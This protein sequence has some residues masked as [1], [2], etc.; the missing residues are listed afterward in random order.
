ME[1]ERYRKAHLK[2]NPDYPQVS[3]QTSNYLNY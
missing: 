3:L 1:C 2:H